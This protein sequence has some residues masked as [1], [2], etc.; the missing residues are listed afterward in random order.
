MVGVFLL[1]NMIPILESEEVWSLENQ[2]IIHEGTV[3]MVMAF[4]LKKPRNH[5]TWGL[6]RTGSINRLFFG[7]LLWGR[8]FASLESASTG[9]R[10]GF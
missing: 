6:H 10:V 3:C 8:A 9:A 4:V 7:G 2:F 5:V 1:V